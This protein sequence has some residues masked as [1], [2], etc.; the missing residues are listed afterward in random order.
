[1][2]CASTIALIKRQSR[3][4]EL[5]TNSPMSD[6]CKWPFATCRAAA[7]T[8]SLTEQS[9]VASS[10]RTDLMSKRPN[11]WKQT[12][13]AQPEFFAC[14]PKLACAVVGVISTSYGASSRV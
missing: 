11:N 6:V 10:R 2:G 14:D 13:Y 12:R 1:M 5:L 7:L 4:C 8:W 9:D 3:M